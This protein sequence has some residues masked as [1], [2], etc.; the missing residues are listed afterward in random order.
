MTELVGASLLTLGLLLGATGLLKF[1][2]IREQEKA[3]IILMDFLLSNY[4]KS[5]DKTNG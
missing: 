5:K 4:D 2:L 3:T 1:V